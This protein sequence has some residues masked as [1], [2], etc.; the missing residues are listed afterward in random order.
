MRFN[1]PPNWPPAPPGWVP[2]SSWV[3]DP[4]WPPPPPGWQL[5]VDDAAPQ[6]P[7][8][9]PYQW[10][11]QQPPRSHKALW[12]ALAAVAVVALVV[13]VAVFAFGFGGKAGDKTASAKPD[14]TRLTDNLLV[15]RSAFADFSGGTWRSG[16]GVTGQKQSATAGISVSPSECADLFGD[17]GSAVQTAIAS[18]TDERATGLR[19]TQVD[20]AITP[21]RQNLADL[22]KKCRSFTMSFDLPG[23][24]VAVQTQV[25]P[26]DVSGVPPWAVAAT[27]KSVTSPT[28]GITSM[29]MSVATVAGYY[30]GILVMA[31]R[32]EFTPRSSD[33]AP[34]D[35]HSAGNLVKLFNA[36]VAKL[37]AAP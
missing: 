17:V 26:L 19:S 34:I 20:L 31:S 25:D 36:Q 29:S 28:A 23:Q 35:S 30:R 1:P 6:Y 21:S 2:G 32:N 9:Y 27:V 10:P 14:I 7:P 3:P 24:T 5:W 18:L 33:S 4:S 13:V 22:V 16:P 15:D 12:I 11:P 8:Q 37:E